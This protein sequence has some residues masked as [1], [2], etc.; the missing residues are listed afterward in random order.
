MG[1][2]VFRLPPHARLRRTATTWKAFVMSSRNLRAAPMDDTHVA[3]H[4]GN[5]F[6]ALLDVKPS[7]GSHYIRAAH[8]TAIRP[9]W[10]EDENWIGCDVTAL[11]GSKRRVNASFE[12]IMAAVSEAEGGS[13]G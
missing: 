11:D 12:Q 2:S 10:D 4:W 5:G 13:N 3:S 7:N 9:A 8:V 6:I 1:V